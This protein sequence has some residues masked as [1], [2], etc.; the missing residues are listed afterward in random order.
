MICVPTCVKIKEMAEQIQAPERHPS[1]QKH[2]RQFWSQILL[3]M[4]L[5]ALIVIAV[6]VLAGVATFGIEGDPPR[7]AAI[8]TIWL[9]IPVMFFGLLFLAIIAGLIYLLTL[10]L[11]AIPPYTSKAQYYAYRVSGI[12]KR[13]SDGATKPVFFVES[14]LASV[15]AFFGRK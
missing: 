10:S 5:A 11:K 7:W 12:G 3:P 1:Y 14:I 8:S 4:V 9:V 13:I 6:A 15:K 2:Q